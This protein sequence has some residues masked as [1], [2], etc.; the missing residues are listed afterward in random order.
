MIAPPSDCGCRVPRGCASRRAVQVTSPP[1]DWRTLALRYSRT[2]TRPFKVLASRTRMAYAPRALR[3]PGT[4]GLHVD[5][6]HPQR[7]CPFVGE[8]LM[9]RT[10]VIKDCPSKTCLSPRMMISPTSSISRRL[11][12]SGS[13]SRW[14]FRSIG[15]FLDSYNVQ[16]AAAGNWTNRGFGRSR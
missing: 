16:M 10:D 12:S 6:Q 4:S 3:Q 15:V 5:P 2:R 14:L 1:R 8:A 9:F 13:G 11:L 7:F